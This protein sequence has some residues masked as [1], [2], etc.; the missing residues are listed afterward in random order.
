MAKRS[1]VWFSMLLIGLLLVALPLGSFLYLK[2]GVNYRLTSLSELEPLGS[3]EAF[4]LAE[5]TEENPVVYL[6]YTTPPSLKDS[7]AITV[8]KVHEAFTHE[9]AVVFVG[10][11][12]SSFQIIEDLP[13]SQQIDR[14]DD[15]VEAFR[16]LTANSTFCENVPLEQQGILVDREGMVRRCYDLHSGPDVTRMVEHLTIL[17]PPAPIEDMILEREKEY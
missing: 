13:Q 4:G 5:S 6:L 14:T 12:K 17:V 10:I 9:P 7:V 3:A 8:E 11:G 15:K 2:A 16:K 1:P